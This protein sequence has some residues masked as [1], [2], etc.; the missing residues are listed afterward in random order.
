MDIIVQFAREEEAYVDICVAGLRLR[1]LFSYT[2]MSST[3]QNSPPTNHSLFLTCSS[4][5]DII[6][7]HYIIHVMFDTLR[8]WGPFWCDT[9][10]LFDSLMARKEFFLASQFH[11]HKDT[12]PQ[13]MLSQSQ[14]RLVFWGDSK[15]RLQDKFYVFYRRW[16]PFLLL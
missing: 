13:R 15:C 2:L 10:G 6:S 7:W 1:W 5:V 11:F 16:P 9:R 4:F 14:A 12:I 3:K 8:S